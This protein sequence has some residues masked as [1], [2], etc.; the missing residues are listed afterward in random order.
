MDER[1]D[2]LVRRHPRHVLLR[3]DPRHPVVW[4]D[5][6][7]LQLGADHVVAV[8]TDVDGADERLLAALARGV[9]G[10]PSALAVVARAPADQ[11]ARRLAELSP[12]M[13]PA[14]PRPTP[15]EVAVVGDGLLATAVADLAEASGLVV[16][17]AGHDD[18]G[19]AARAAV[20]VADHVLAPRD[21]HRWLRDD[22][23]HLLVRRGDATVDVGPFVHPGA[24]A[25]SRCLDLDRTDADAC[26]P[27]LATQLW[28]R[29][30]PPLPRLPRDLAS[31]LAVQRL[32][33]EVG[34]PGPLVPATTA[35]RVDAVTGAVSARET[36]PHP[37]CGCAAPPGTCSD[38][39]LRHAPGRS[40]STTVAGVAALG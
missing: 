4:R 9:R 6:S 21:A 7:T 1:G 5:P 14:R 33:A 13:G 3:L 26:W 11:V 18:E 22:V 20:L 38:D 36:R 37:A 39:A 8:L 17:R 29:A 25:C 35:L 31:A 10:G 28:R 27:A 12:A 15:P 23:P 30:A 19:S 16:R 32:R 2:D 24:T 40:G 34:L